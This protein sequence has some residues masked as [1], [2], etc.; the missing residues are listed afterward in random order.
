MF[1]EKN[2]KK[3]LTIYKRIDYLIPSL[4]RTL[5]PRTF[6]HFEIV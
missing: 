1:E 2:I 5:G 3:R 6:E 4:L